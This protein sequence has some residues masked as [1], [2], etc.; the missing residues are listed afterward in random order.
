MRASSMR[1]ERSPCV[2]SAADRSLRL[3]TGP[4]D[5]QAL[6]GEVQALGVP[7]GLAELLQGAREELGDSGRRSVH[8]AGDLARGKFL[9]A[10][11]ADHL[12]MIGAQALDRLP[13]PCEPVLSAQPPRGGYVR[14]GDVPLEGRD[15]AHLPALDLLE[16]YMLGDSPEPAEEAALAAPAELLDRLESPEESLLAD[17]RRLDLPPELWAEERMDERFQAALMD[18]EEL[19]EGGPAPRLGLLNQDPC[20]LD[21]THDRFHCIP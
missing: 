7:K 6:W 15:A 14:S 17:V 4:P 11:K 10:G 13:E 18:R 1:R 2:L 19:L 3:F 9:D 20:R 16:H 5:L 8:E 21:L 12:A